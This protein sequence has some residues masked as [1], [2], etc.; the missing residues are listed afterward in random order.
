MPHR[1]ATI[2]SKIL[3]HFSQI[4]AVLVSFI[5]P[6]VGVLIA[7]GAFILL[8]TVVGV[9]KAKKIKQKV[10]SRRLSSIVNKMLVYQLTTITFFTLDWFIINDIILEFLSVEFALTKAI[11]VV[12]ISIEFFSINESFEVATGKG[13]LARFKDLMNRYKENKKALREED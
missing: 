8:D 13:L 2:G 6:V 1:L 5:S 3:I 4:L 7:V 9:W 12:L 11:A 10:T